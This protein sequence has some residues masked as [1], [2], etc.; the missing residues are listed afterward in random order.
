MDIDNGKTW[1]YLIDK[2]F[3]P[4]RNAR[5]VIVCAAA[6]SIVTY[7]PSCPAVPAIEVPLAVAP[8]ELPITPVI[9]EYRCQFVAL[10]TNLAALGLLVANLGVEFSFGR[11]FSLDLPFY[12]SPYDIT[13]TFRVRVLGTQPELRYWLN[14]DRP[15]SRNSAKTAVAE[16]WSIPNS[17]TR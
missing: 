10:K 3:R 17:P 7:R 4:A 1:G 6:D 5:M 13:S 2:P 14:R 8:I 9:P 12:Y 11:G 16:F 15:G